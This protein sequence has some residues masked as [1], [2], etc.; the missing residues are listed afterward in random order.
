MERERE[1]ER[2]REASIKSGCHSSSGDFFAP[3]GVFLG[4]FVLREKEKPFIRSLL[5]L[6]S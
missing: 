3:L 4:A 1:R 2:G 5:G 6:I